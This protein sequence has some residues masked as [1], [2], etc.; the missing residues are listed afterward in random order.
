MAQSSS[1][2]EEFLG[3][4]I[5]LE[6]SKLSSTNTPVKYDF[7]AITSN[8][9]IEK[10]IAQREVENNK[11]IGVIVEINNS[12]NEVLVLTKGVFK[13]A[14][15]NTIDSVNI[16]YGTKLYLSDVSAGKLKTTAPT[17][18]VCKCISL[19]TKRGI[20]IDATAVQE[21][22]MN[23]ASYDAIKGNLDSFLSIQNKL[24]SLENSIN[25]IDLDFLTNEVSNIKNNLANFIAIHMLTTTAEKGKVPKIDEN[26]NIAAD[27]FKG[28][29]TTGRRIVNPIGGELSLTSHPNTGVIKVKLPVSWTN[30]M[31]VAVAK[32]FD[33]ASGES[34]DVTFGGYNSVATSAWINTFA[35]IS[36]DKKIDRNLSVRFGHDGGTCCVYIGETNSSWEYLQ[37]F[38]TDVQ[39]GYSS[40][41][42]EDWKKNWQISVETTLGTIS[43]T[44]TDTQIGRNILNSQLTR[45]S[46]GIIKGRVSSGT[47]NVEDITVTQLRTFIGNSS[48][49]LDGLM[50]ISDKVKLDASTNINT[51][52]AIVKRD[53]NGDFV[54]RNITATSFIG[55][56]NGNANSATVF[57]TARN[58][59]ISGDGTG[60]ATNFDGSANITIPFTLAD[61]GVTAGTYKSITVDA[62]G[63][64]TAGTN[65]TTDMNSMTMKGNNT[66][67]T[68]DPKDLTVS[69]VD[70]ML[71]ITKKAMMYG[72]IFG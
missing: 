47:G 17:T 71:G 34:F 63:R 11:L 54:A 69:E 3:T 51:A 37:V 13:T 21:I 48:S 44:Q 2:K 26:R 32:I 19:M 24:V 5:R 40:V 49:V 57:Q 68:S 9:T 36:A 67:T 30:H 35:Y 1:L 14:Y 8:G 16:T 31:I 38:V 18:G 45:V 56:L 65:P 4:I 72:I 33:Y 58:I 53:S 42:V 22:F 43:E 39:I 52:N 29:L 60:T 6:K 64:V 23:Q 15:F 55:A 10:A 61:S 27:N 70:V 46:S 66:G 25:N 41:D 7:V 50:S 28:S 20:Y 62:K 59:G 12:T